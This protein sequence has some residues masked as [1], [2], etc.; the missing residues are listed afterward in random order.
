MHSFG[1]L[2]S[3]ASILVISTMGVNSLLRSALNYLRAAELQCCCTGFLNG[4]IPVGILN[5]I[6]HDPCRGQPSM[7]PINP[8]RGYLKVD[9]VTPS[10]LE[11]TEG[12]I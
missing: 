5:G 7:S 6:C 10:L 8:C 1:S 9:W 11:G 3:D 2:G 12:E 4:N